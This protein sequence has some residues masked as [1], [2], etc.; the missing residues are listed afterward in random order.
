MSE[1]P[2]PL[3]DVGPWTALA[4]AFVEADVAAL[5][6]ALA[7]LRSERPEIWKLGE[8][9]FR[10]VHALQA[11]EL[12]DDFLP[13]ANP[14]NR[15]RLWVILTDAEAWAHGKAMGEALKQAAPE[16]LEILRR[17][18]AELDFGPG[19]LEAWNLAVA[20]YGRPPLAVSAGYAK[21][22]SPPG[23]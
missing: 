2:W 12:P 13:G 15:R 3:D 18:P 9:F 22:Q 16:M 6:F 1:S 20:K 14:E 5:H 10:A 4:G 21:G 17:I 19:G 7:G 8:A 23:G 11:G